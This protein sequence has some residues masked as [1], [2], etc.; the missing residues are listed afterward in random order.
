MPQS[1]TVRMKAADAM[2]HG[3]K[4]CKR[5]EM[6]NNESRGASLD[7]SLSPNSGQQ[8]DQAIEACSLRVSVVVT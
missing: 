5:E 6:E 8:H 7:F 2:N 3:I 1:V 4:T